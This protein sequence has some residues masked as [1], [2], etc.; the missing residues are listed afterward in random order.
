MYLADVEECA[1]STNTFSGL[2][3]PPGGSAPNRGT[4]VRIRSILKEGHHSVVSCNVF[5]DLDT[6]HALVL[7]GVNDDYVTGN[8]FDQIG[9][10]C[11]SVIHANLGVTLGVVANAITRVGAAAT[12]EGAIY[13][14]GIHGATLSGNVFSGVPSTMKPIALSGGS[15]NVQVSPHQ[16][17][18]D[19]P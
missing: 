5:N 16:A 13:F 15:G 12:P 2:K 9:P 11:F 14:Q 1:V 7:D 8:V 18:G 4:L 19:T 6:S 3:T 10:S 17:R